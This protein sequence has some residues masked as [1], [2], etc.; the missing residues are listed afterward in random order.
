MPL[1]KILDFMI[2]KTHHINPELSFW[3]KGSALSSCL[4]RAL[5]C[6]Q[7]TLS[8]VIC[9]YLWLSDE[10]FQESLWTPVK[11]KLASN[12]FLSS[13]KPDLDKPL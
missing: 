8:A 9:L 11:K 4:L 13:E 12:Q 10:P 1:D 2:D 3:R 5:I 6:C 7:S